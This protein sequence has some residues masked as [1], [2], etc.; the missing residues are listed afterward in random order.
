MTCRRPA[1]TIAFTTFSAGGSLNRGGFS[2]VSPRRRQKGSCMEQVKRAQSQGCIPKESWLA[3]YG[4]FQLSDNAGCINSRTVLVYPPV[5]DKE[6]T[7]EDAT[8]LW[9]WGG[10]L[11]NKWWNADHRAAGV[12]VEIFI[13]NSGTT[14]TKGTNNTCNNNV[15]GTYSYLTAYR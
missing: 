4:L 12:R 7:G 9:W 5:L 6:W 2:S 1:P 10:A 11:G 3:E 14:R 8:V 15:A 13:Y